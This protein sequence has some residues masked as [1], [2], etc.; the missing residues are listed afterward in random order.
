M[1]K[2]KSNSPDEIRTSVS[3][4]YSQ[5]LEKR[6]EE[7]EIKEEKKR[8]KAEEKQIL[9]ESSKDDSENKEDVTKMTKKQK[10][11]A[12]MDAWKE[13]IVGLTGDDLD[14]VEEKKRGSYHLC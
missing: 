9:K 13:I 10:R 1:D 6:R 4:L 8:Q 7:N 12:E 2:I 3:S 5:L 14:Y 11:Q